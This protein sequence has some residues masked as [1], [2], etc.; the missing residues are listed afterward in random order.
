M[1]RK[2]NANRNSLSPNH[3]K[4]IDRELP[5]TNLDTSNYT[6]RHTTHSPSS[7]ASRSL[8]LSSQ[9]HTK[10][11]TNSIRYRFSFTR[12]DCDECVDHAAWRL[13]WALRRFLRFSSFSVFIL[14]VCSVVWCGFWRGG[15]SEM[16]VVDRILESDFGFNF[17]SYAWLGWWGGIFHAF[18]FV[19]A[20]FL[21]SD[22]CGFWSW[23]VGGD[24]VNWMI[25]GTIKTRRLDLVHVWDWKFSAYVET[26]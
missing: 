3:V 22:F 15:R 11:L 14:F 21:L 23:C 2:R 24:V 1:K 10:A 8:L 12:F 19:S 26:D 20:T 9:L 6:C 13:S 5:A 7:S 25:V 4:V 17:C 16:F 18:C